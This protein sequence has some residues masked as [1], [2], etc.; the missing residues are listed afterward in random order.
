MATFVSAE[1]IDT[2]TAYCRWNKAALSMQGDQEEQ[3]RSTYRI[4]RSLGF[5]LDLPFFP[6]FPS[7]RRVGVWRT[8]LL[9][10]RPPL[11]GSSFPSIRYNNIP[12]SA[13]RFLV[14][15]RANLCQRLPQIV[16]HVRLPCRDGNVARHCATS[17][18]TPLM[19][20]HGDFPGQQVAPEE[21]GAVDRKPRSG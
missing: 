2:K 6:L 13:S 7:L 19:E 10:M 12:S 21:G 8:G 16:L 1:C 18:A 17:H 5:R 20:V 11:L 9:P 4:C 15:C 14:A 3:E